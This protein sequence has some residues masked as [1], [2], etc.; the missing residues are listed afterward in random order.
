MV[1]LI[2][3]VSLAVGMVI[4]AMLASRMNVSPSRVQELEN[5]IRSLKESNSDY[6]DS[7]GDHFAMTAELVHHMTESYREVYQHLATGAQD[8]CAPDVANKLLPADSDAVFD[9]AQSEPEP[10]PLIPPKDYAAKQDP[11]QKGALDEGFG[12]DSNKKPAGGDTSTNE[13]AASAKSENS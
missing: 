6:R 4:G 12:L 10:S 2:A 5:Q 13:E 11:E 7:V 9:N 8:L 3:I 1:W